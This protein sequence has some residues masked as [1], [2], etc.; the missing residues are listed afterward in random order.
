M[1]FSKIE[2]GRLD[3]ETVTFDPRAVLEE[4]IELGSVRAT[5]RGLEL[6]YVADGSLPGRVTGDPGRLRQVLLNLVENALKF[7]ERGSVVVRVSTHGGDDARVEMRFA[8]QDTG[9]GIDERAHPQLFRP[10]SQLDRSARRRFGGTGLGLAIS[11][12]LAEAM[13]GTITVDSTLG[14]GSTFTLVLPLGTAP[15]DRVEPRLQ[16]RGTRLRAWVVDGEGPSAQ[17]AAERLRGRDFAVEVLARVE[18]APPADLD[19]ALVHVATL[20]DGEDG[21]ALIAALR[22]T[23]VLLYG[24]ASQPTGEAIAR[25]YGVGGYLPKPFREE[26]LKNRLVALCRGGAPAGESV[27]ALGTQQLV[28]IAGDRQRPRVLVAED[29]PVNQLVASRL[30]ERLGC[31]V[32]LVANGAEAVDSVRVVP[33]AL[34]FMD[35]QMPDLDGFEATRQ[36]R[37][38]EGAGGVRVPI[39]AMTANVLPGIIDQCKDCGM[40]DYV[41]KPIALESLARIL[42]RW[43]YGAHVLGAKASAPQPG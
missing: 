21:A 5:E 3:T 15:Y 1:N 7:T 8:V 14:I 35:C 42:E 33:Y 11:K 22:P 37:A 43:I 25:T 28:A 24:H 4:V 20:E 2:A 27:R 39:V 29:N 40:D 30:L 41:A 31:V 13:G 19:V 38:L 12:R 18:R 32:E 17:L 36:I 10:F 6:G 34:V 16:P 26:S 9:I 23:P